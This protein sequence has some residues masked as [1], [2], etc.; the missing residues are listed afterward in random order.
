MRFY[1]LKVLNAKTGAPML[2]STSYPGGVGGGATGPAFFGATAAAFGIPGLTQS[3][4]DPGALNIVFSVFVYPQHTPMGGSAITLEGLPPAFLTN[5]Q[6]FSGQQLELR[7]GMG[8]GLPLA[9]PAQAGLLLQGTIL[10]AYGNWVGTE[11]YAAFVVNASTFT[12]ENPGNFVLNWTAGTALATALKNTLSV[13]YPT[14]TISMNIANVVQSFDE[15]H[16]CAT[17]SNLARLLHDITPTKVQIV[18][19]GDTIFVFDATY[20]PKPTQLS[21][22]DL[23]GQPQWIK[24][25]I[26]Q[27]RFTMRA[28]LQVGD[29]IEFPGA[30]G[31]GPGGLGGFVTTAQSAVP[32]MTNYQSA[33]SGSFNVTAIRHIGNLR[34]PNGNDWCTVVYAAVPAPSA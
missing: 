18:I 9:K 12:L 30:A 4:Y 25:Q 32:S 11:I 8:P 10:Q 16:V 23:I 6:Q 29:T 31:S 7:G 34:Q 5:A 15:K 3:P 33:I 1:D 22:E 14:A 2:H 26:I 24:P 13:A 20:K 27:A 28:D 19:N 21:F 17:L